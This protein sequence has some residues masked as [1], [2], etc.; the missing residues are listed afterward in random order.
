MKDLRRM[1]AVALK[2]LRQM[3]R[4]RISVI[5]IVLIPVIDLLL[6]GYAI[7]LNPRNLEAAVV[8]NEWMI[9]GAL[10]AAYAQATSMRGPARDMD[11]YL[12]PWAPASA[13]APFYLRVPQAERERLAREQIAFK[14]VAKD[15]E[16]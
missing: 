7:N 16:L 15:V 3:G 1:W 4:D 10:S 12:Y 8:D 2:E 14:P 11:R 9:V 13:L 5:M 6:F